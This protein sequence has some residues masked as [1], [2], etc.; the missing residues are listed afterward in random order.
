MAASNQAEVDLKVNVESPLT[1]VTLWAKSVSWWRA[2]LHGKLIDMGDSSRVTVYFEWGRTT[3]Y[4][5]TTWPRVL[6]S[7]RRFTT[8][9]YWL[10]PNTTYHFRAVAIA[11]GKYYYGDDMTFTTNKFHWWWWR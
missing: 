2:T 5:H 11:D 4:G 9:I 3:D 7:P 1:V 10:S 8:S 6:R